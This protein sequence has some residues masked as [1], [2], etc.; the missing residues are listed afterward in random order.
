[1]ATTLQDY[2][3][4]SYTASTKFSNNV[5]QASFAGI[6]IIWIFKTTIKEV[7]IL[8]SDLL[9]PMILIVVT[10][11]LDSLQYYVSSIIWDRYCNNQEDSI[12]NITKDTEV[13]PPR[14]YVKW[15]Q[16]FY[17]TKAITIAIAYCLLLW[18]LIRTLKFI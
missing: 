4:A 11:I 15:I 9:L 12:D 17:H 1:M 16:I 8:P 5:R 13:N 6:A 2:R 3:D 14:H 10:L 7:N 18:Y